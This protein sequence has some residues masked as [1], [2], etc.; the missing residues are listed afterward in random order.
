MSGISAAERD[1]L[2]NNFEKH[3]KATD[4]FGERQI[5]ALLDIF[6]DIL[7]TITEEEE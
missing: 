1:K 3:L 6:Y 7:T 2:I 4:A 5:N